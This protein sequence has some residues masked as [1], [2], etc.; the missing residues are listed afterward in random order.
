M[1]AEQRTD[2]AAERVADALMN[3]MLFF[4]RMIADVARIAVLALIGLG[5]WHYV[6]MPAMHYPAC[7]YWQAFWTAFLYYVVR[8]V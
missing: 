7:S 1:T 6:V 5:F 8:E 2:K 4:V 3:T